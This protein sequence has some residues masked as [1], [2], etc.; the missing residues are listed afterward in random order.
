[1]SDSQSHSDSQSPS[2]SDGAHERRDDSDLQAL[3]AL[4][5]V[6][7][8]ESS[9]EHADRA[10][11]RARAAFMEAHAYADAPWRFRAVRVWSR[12]F[13]PA[14]LLATCVLYLTWAVQAASSLYR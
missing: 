1:M 8:C 10:F 3:R 7:L 12:V 11:G 2:P 14:L 5:S 6:A 4:A 13:V 9:S